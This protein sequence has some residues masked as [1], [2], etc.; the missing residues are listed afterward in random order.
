MY[1]L[2][3]KGL[4]PSL[5]NWLSGTHWRTKNR[6]KDE[7]HGIMWAAIVDA[8]LPKKLNTPLTLSVTQVCKRLRDVDNGIISAKFFLDTLRLHGYIPDDTP[9]FVSEVRLRSV[10]GKEDKCLIEIY[11]AN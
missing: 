6:Q 2:E 10:K 7:W 8:K 5:N 4:P 3:I 1:S 9:E 11:K